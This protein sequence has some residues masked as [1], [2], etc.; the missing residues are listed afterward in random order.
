MVEAT[1]HELEAGVG[2]HMGSGIHHWSVSRVV[3]QYYNVVAATMGA[4]K[5]T[6]PS[7]YSESALRPRLPGTLQREAAYWCWES[8]QL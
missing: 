3:W 5:Q 8:W 2:H 6:L 1:R 4:D 7:L